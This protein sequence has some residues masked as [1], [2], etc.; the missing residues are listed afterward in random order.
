[1]DSVSAFASRTQNFE[2][3]RYIQCN[4][5][6]KIL[7][8]FILQNF[9]EEL[10]Y[11]THTVKRI[12]NLVKF[13]K[14]QNFCAILRYSRTKR[15]Y[16][17]DLRL[18]VVCFLPQTEVNLDTGEPQDNLSPACIEWC[19]SVGSSAKIIQDVLAGP[20]VNVMRAI[21]DGIDRANKLAPSNAQRIQ[22]W[23]ILPRDFSL[24]GGELGR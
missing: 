21:Q 8:H 7:Q 12:L 19:H 6:K 16:S 20:D 18:N 13:G 15:S 11:V 22:K 2:F 10:Q 1:M 9:L 5:A 24:P 4:T 14:T 17:E 3:R 23:T